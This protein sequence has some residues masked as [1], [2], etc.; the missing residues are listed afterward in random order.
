MSDSADSS[1]GSE[2]IAE[3]EDGGQSQMIAADK[4]DS[5]CDLQKTADSKCKDWKSFL[6]KDERLTKDRENHNITAEFDQ[7]FKTVHNSGINDFKGNLRSWCL[8]FFVRHI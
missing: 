2:D 7:G 5:V 3:Q 6:Q 1:E 8:I 4:G